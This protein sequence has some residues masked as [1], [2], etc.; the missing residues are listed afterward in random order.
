MNQGEMLEKLGIFWQ[1][2]F[3]FKLPSAG[4]PKDALH[5][6]K[7]NIA[8]ITY[9]YVTTLERNPTKLPQTKAILEG[10]SVTGMSIDDMMQVKRY[11]DAATL[12]MEMVSNGAFALNEAT[13]CALHN[14]VGK[15][16]ALTWGKFRDGLVAIL[17]VDQYI[18]PDSKLLTGI[19]AKGFAFLEDEVKSPQERAVA[20]F[21]FMARTQFFHDANKRTASLMMNGVLLSSGI[22]PTTIMNRNSEEFHTKLT[23]FYNTGDASAMMRF[24]ERSM[25]RLYSPQAQGKTI[26]R[27]AGQGS[28]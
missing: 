20:T 16:E 13:A 11:G 28:G 26:V 3:D 24:F 10:Q 18:P 9:H 15:E 25:K 1:G 6:F 2:G 17:D 5:I 19:A 23:D 22:F 14:C 21:L 4:S 12:L 8:P 7:Q 27:S